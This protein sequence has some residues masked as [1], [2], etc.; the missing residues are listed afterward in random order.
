MGNG[1]TVATRRTL[2]GGA[3]AAGCIFA[4][5]AAA[6]TQTEDPAATFAALLSRYVSAHPDGLNRVDY[7]VWR[8][9]AEDMRRLDAAIVAWS[10]L[11]PSRMAHWDALAFWANLY[12]AITLKVVLRRYPV[13]S[14]RDIHSEGVFLDPRALIG[15]W[16]TKLITVER[17]RLSLDD[18]EN[19]TLRPLAHDPRIHYAINCAS[20]GCPNLQRAPWRGETMQQELDNAARSYINNS[21][22]VRVLTDGSVRASSIYDWFKQDFGGNDAGVLAHVRRYADPPL[23]ARLRSVTRISAYDYDWALNDIAHT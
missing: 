17:R 2:L 10:V 16:R 18:I 14:I 21:R 15:P 23:A 13:S 12:N 4:L 6:Q 5:D 19:G 9:S 22:G 11:A 8:A 1:M 7:T 20:V 3:A